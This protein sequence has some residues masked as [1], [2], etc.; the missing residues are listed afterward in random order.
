MRRNLFIEKN[1][2]NLGNIIPTKIQLNGKLED[3]EF[4]DWETGDVIH[5]NGH[6]HFP[7]MAKLSISEN[8]FVHDSLEKSNSRTILDF[9]L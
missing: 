2:D 9:E 1:D 5:L 7:N 4:L 3:S 6:A 8:I